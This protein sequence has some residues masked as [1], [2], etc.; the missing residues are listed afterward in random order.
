M[1]EVEI[2]D[3]SSIE[4]RNLML[5]TLAYES[6]NIDS[7][8]KA[9]KLSGYQG[10]QSDLYHLMEGLAIKKGLIKPDIPLHGTAWGGSGLNASST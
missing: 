7:E 9:F 4:I 2:R 8:G 6:E 10:A 3:L 1:M 5:D